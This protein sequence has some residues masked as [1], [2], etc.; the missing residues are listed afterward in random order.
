[1]AIV[2]PKLSVFIHGKMHFVCIVYNTTPYRRVKARAA[3]GVFFIRLPRLFPLFKGTTRTRS[4][5]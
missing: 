4:L 5:C 3:C 2:F 1:M